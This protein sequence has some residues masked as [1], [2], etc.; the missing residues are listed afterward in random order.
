M[1]SRSRT[2]QPRPT[3]RD[4]IA[5]GRWS[6]I[7]IVLMAALAGCEPAVTGPEPSALYDGLGDPA[8]GHIAFLQECAQCHASRDGYDLAAF[9]FSRFDVIRR[10]LGHVDSTTSR[11]IAAYIETLEPNGLF[12]G[13][14]FQPG[15]RVGDGDRE[16]WIDALGTSGWPTGLTAEALRAIDPRA[17]QVP[18]AMPEWS[19]EGSD[20]DWM[21]DVALP[22]QVLDYSGGAI[23]TGLAA[24]YADRTES[25]LLRVLAP[26]KAATEGL[27][28]VCWQSDPDPCFNAR[29]W[30]ASLGAQHYL[31]L[32]PPAAVP[33]EV[34]QV[35]WDVGESAIAL[36]GDAM[37]RGEYPGLDRAIGST[38]IIGARWMYLAYSYHPEAFNE[39]SGYMGT[40]LQAQELHRVAVFVAL[41]RMVGDGPAHQKH[42]DQFL[43]DGYLAVKFA[44]TADSV[45]AASADDEV[46]PGVTEFVFE[47]Y[48]ERLEAGRPAGLDLGGARELVT[49]AWSEGQRWLPQN[50]AGLARVIALRERVME[51]L[52]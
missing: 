41:R 49:L 10:S 40:F 26:F 13:P 8:A 20:E 2:R 29:R 12:G 21:P 43:Q 15:G 48:I 16:Y 27:G 1:K 30:M 44:A 35:W 32:G 5:L 52:Q 22:V 9:G 25:N 33:V 47:Y 38:F 36:Q 14:P 18:L 46:G 45:R 50:S 37:S 7:V 19:L 11:D 39:P 51:L 28:L 34:A 17:L 31:R 24:Y 23:R 42:A 3:R 6:A 4:E